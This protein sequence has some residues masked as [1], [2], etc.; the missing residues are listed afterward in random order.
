MFFL[1]QMWT[2]LGHC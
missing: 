2:V 1:T